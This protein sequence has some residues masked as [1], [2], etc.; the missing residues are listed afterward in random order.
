[1]SAPV[2]LGLLVAATAVIWPLNRWALRHGATPLGTGIILSLVALAGGAVSALSAG[3]PLYDPAAFFYGSLGGISFAV[4]FV[5]LILKCLGEGPIAPAAAAYSLA[6]AGSVL[7]GLSVPYGPELSTGIIASFAAVLVSLGLIGLAPMRAGG[8]RER[9]WGA[10][11]VGGWAFMAVTGATQFLAGRFAPSSPFGYIIAQKL[12]SLLI[13]LLVASTRGG[14]RVCAADLLAGAGT[15]LVATAV[16]W[17]GTAATD[18]MVSVW[19][20]PFSVASPL[21]LVLVGSALLSRDRIGAWGWAACLLALAAMV[22]L[23]VSLPGGV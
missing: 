9:E 6:L 21:A 11:A 15:G 2:A 1:M 23:T 7:A 16:V 13:L 5:L 18:A 20:Y 22:L 10:R 14:A 3:Q 8:K 12:V 4:G 17:L 19:V